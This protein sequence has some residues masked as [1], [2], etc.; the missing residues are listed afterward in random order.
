MTHLLVVFADHSVVFETALTEKVCLFKQMPGLL[1]DSG[2]MPRLVASLYLVVGLFWVA[3]YSR[4]AARWLG[5]SAELGLVVGTWKEFVYVLIEA[6]TLYVGLR[7][8]ESQQAAVAARASQSAAA[9]Q[10]LFDSAPVPMWLA[11]ADG[12]IG[13]A[14]RALGRALGF[15]AAEL[16]G[17]PATDLLDPADVS[18][19]YAAANLGAGV[20]TGIFRY[21]TAAGGHLVAN[22]HTS[23]VTRDGSL[24]TL[25]AL[26]NLT[27]LRAAERLLAEREATFHELL[28]AM[29]ESVWIGDG[30]DFRSLYVSPAVERITGWT[31]AELLDGRVSWGQMVHPDDLGGAMAGIAALAVD[32]PVSSEMRILRKDG[33]EVWIETSSVRVAGTR[34]ASDRIVSLV[35]D[36]SER[37]AAAEDLRLAEVVFQ[38][39]QQGIVVTAADLRILRSNPA[40]AALTGEELEVPGAGEPRFLGVEVADADVLAQIRSS[41]GATGAWCGEVWWRKKDGE[42]FL[43]GLSIG[44]A[45]GGSHEEP[46]FVVVMSDLTATRRDAIRIDRLAHFDSVTGLPNRRSFEDRVEAAWTRSEHGGAVIAIGLDRFKAINDALGQQIG[47]DFLAEIA[48]RIHTVL[49][50]GEALARWRSDT[51]V[52][53]VPAPV[54]VAEVTGRILAAVAVPFEVGAVTIHLTASAGVATYPVDGATAADLTRRAETAM[55]HAKSRGRNRSVM[56]TAQL[57]HAASERI[58]FESRLRRAIQR[59]EFVLYY[60]PQ[61]SLRTGALTGVEALIRWQDPELGL[62]PPGAFISAAEDSGLILPIGVWALRE[63]CAVARRW[64]AAGEPVRVSVNI[65]AVQFLHAEFVEVVA[66]VLAETGLSPHL[67]ELEVT[68]GVVIAEGAGVGVRLQRL[69]ALGVGLSIDDFGTGYSSLAY[70]RRFPFDK[71]KIDQSFVRDMLRDADAAALTRAVVQ[72]GKA[73]RLTVI[74]EGVEVQEQDAFLTSID[75]DEA[76]GWLYAK[77]MP[78]A[79]FEAWR[80]AHERGL[81]AKGGSRPA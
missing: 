61:V 24:C 68:E 70:L 3:L 44:S 17:R 8:W 71:L 64:N 23:A 48:E 81:K 51:F 57:E 63:A 26:E 62:V 77:A 5:N 21:R 49:A 19:S 58:S 80:D 65:S 54:A 76:Q 12:R 4:L 29:S 36:V 40:F 60:Q 56:F 31:P 78:A 46:K 32:A 25:V 9:W 14:N 20:A 35:S 53:W 59:E 74:A 37:R 10:E 55:F 18:R 11:P 2:E 27:E 52:V 45:P 69:H 6:G 34:G 16:L 75:C 43:A 66:A 41:L 50:A 38:R 30:T 28:G 7:W 42:P 15:S 33:R 13:A 79:E 47:D 73:L 1:S 72:L 67:L 22:T 39:A